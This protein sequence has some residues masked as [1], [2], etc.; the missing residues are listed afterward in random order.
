MKLK[1]IVCVAYTDYV[2]HD[3]CAALAFAEV[4]KKTAVKD[5]R[6]DISILK[7]EPED[8]VK[9]GEDE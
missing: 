2:F 7:D 3:G 4:A 1:Y 5:L 9:E 8:T 6:I